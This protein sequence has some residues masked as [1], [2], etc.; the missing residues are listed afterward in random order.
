MSCR[1]NPLKI[2]NSPY[3]NQVWQKYRNYLIVAIDQQDK[4][5]YLPVF[6]Q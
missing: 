1:G 2:K 5:Y 3:K 4:G 6:W